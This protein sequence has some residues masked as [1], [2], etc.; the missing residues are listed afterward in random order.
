M[1]EPSRASSLATQSTESRNRMA[2]TEL[3]RKTQENGAVTRSTL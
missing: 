2:L 3:N 1:T